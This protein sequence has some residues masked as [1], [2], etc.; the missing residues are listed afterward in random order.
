MLCTVSAPPSQSSKDME[1]S[2]SAPNIRFSCVERTRADN[3][4]ALALWQ[5]SE[6]VC[7]R[8]GAVDAA[9]TIV[10]DKGNDTISADHYV[11][12]QE[13]SKR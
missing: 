4:Q 11:F 10:C 1:P 6:I 2:S 12:S 13:P 8:E 9:W 7:D 5:D 3:I